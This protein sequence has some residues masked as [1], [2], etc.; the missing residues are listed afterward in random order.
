LK[1][2]TPSENKIG[3]VILLT[4]KIAS[5]KSY[6]AENYVKNNRAMILSCDDL[7]LALFD[8]CLGEEHQKIEQRAF[9]FFYNQ[10]VQLA[11]LGI[12]ALLDFGFWTHESRIE[13][14]KFFEKQGI[15]TETWYFEIDDELRKNRLNERN[16]KLQESQGNRRE[17]IID[18][19]MLERFDAMYEVPDEIGIIKI[20]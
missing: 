2:Q 14:C 7:I 19:K 13:A 20:I 8:D 10:A 9:T 3:K 11:N 16:K 1:N 18:S 6:Y 15:E 17:Y 5:G 4:G 12:D